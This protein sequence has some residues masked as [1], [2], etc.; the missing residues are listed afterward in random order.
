[1]SISF[2]PSLG[3]LGFAL[4]GVFFVNYFLSDQTISGQHPTPVEKGFPEKDYRAKLEA[5]CNILNNHLISLDRESNW[6]PEYYTPLEADVEVRSRSHG[7]TGRRVTDL[8]SALRSDKRS[9]GF[10]VLGEPG[11]GKSVALRK[12]SLE[13]LREVPKTGRVP[14]YI[15]LREW[16]PR[17]RSGNG[18]ATNH[19]WTED[20]KPSIKKDLYEFVVENVM[21]YSP[22]SS[23][24][25]TLTRCGSTEGCS[26]CSTRSTRYLNCWT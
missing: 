23:W 19:R 25:H 21:I 3:V 18:G 1:L 15:N 13:M 14:I 8:L 4:A 9:Q 2:E 17:E 20:N 7:A 22:R 16:L 10:L 11:A 6:S 5:F 26:S 24:I 12:L